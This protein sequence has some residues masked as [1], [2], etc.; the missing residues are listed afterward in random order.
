MV[1]RK[2]LG[3]SIDGMLWFRVF[4][5][6]RYVSFRYYNFSVKFSAYAARYRIMKYR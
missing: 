2:S 5:C 4:I 3:K 6:Y 1:M